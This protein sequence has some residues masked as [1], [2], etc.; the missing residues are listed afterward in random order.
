MTWDDGEPA[1][2]RVFTP[3]LEDLL[4]PARHP[5]G[6]P[7]GP[8]RG[9]RGLASGGLRGGGLP[10]A[11]NAL[12]ARTRQPRLCLAGGCAMNSVANG[13]IREE[14]PFREVY[15]QPAAG[16]NGTALG[17]AF[18]V[19]SISSSGSRGASSWT[20]RY[21]G[22]EFDDA[23]DAAGA[24]RA[25]PRAGA[26][27]HARSPSSSTTRTSC[28]AA[29]P[30]GSP[31]ARSWAGSRAAW[32]GGRGPSAT[33][34]SSPIPGART[35]ARSSMRRSS[36]ARRSGPSPHPSSRRRSTSTS[37]ERCRTRS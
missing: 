32:S 5:D 29:P 6:A 27:G 30:S 35:C 12:H 33:G 21:W 2:G 28:A 20:T 23:A 25:A 3:K 11:P 37:S 1:I 18:Y 26:P 9:H 19:S 7:H 4:G 31:R 15:V 8:A 24:R 34:A 13:K 36:S 10:R 22:P 16:D 17:A 14:T